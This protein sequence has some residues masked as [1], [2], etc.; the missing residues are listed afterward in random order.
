MFIVAI[1]L[2]LLAAMGVYGLNATAYDV[3]A[4]GQGR[5]AAQAQHAADVGI[6]T[7]AYGANVNAA[8]LYNQL[9]TPPP[10]GI[11]M[12]CFSAKPVIAGDGDMNRAANACVAADSDKLKS[13]AKSTIWP[14]PDTNAGPN[15]GPPPP[16]PFMKDSFGVVPDYANV[17]VEYT[18][19]IDV[20]APAGF[21]S[22]MVFTSVRVSVRV[23]MRQQVD[24]TTRL[25][26]DTVAMGRGRILI[27]P[28]AR[29]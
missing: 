15:P 25:A 1:T 27:G 26:P 4:A 12:N 17:R 8:G 23:E 21:D 20:A 29:N 18:N 24:A 16:T 3:R 2:A 28:H 10:P 11:T 14:G 6:Q 9:M 5:A 13:W 22:S 19:P 7:A